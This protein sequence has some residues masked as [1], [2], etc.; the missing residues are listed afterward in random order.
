MINFY[1]E[2]DNGELTLSPIIGCW[3][4]VNEGKQWKL[5]EFQ[6]CGETHFIIAYPTLTEA[7]DA[8]LELT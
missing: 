6:D 8:A 3:F 5:Y 2:F 4:V 1:T 7:H